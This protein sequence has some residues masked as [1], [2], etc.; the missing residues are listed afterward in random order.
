M[1]NTGGDPSD[2]VDQNNWR[3]MS[4]DDGLEKIIKD[5]IDKNPK[6]VG[7]YKAGKQNSLQ[8]MAGQVMKETRGTAKPEKVL[9]I[10]K[11]LLS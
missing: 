11:K 3:Q 8:F 9:E 1:F 5:I 6:A 2:I 7:D 10:L 4:D